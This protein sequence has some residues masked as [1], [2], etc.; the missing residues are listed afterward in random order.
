[1]SILSI[2]LPPELDAWLDLASGGKADEKAEMIRE[3]IRTFRD[4]R[5]G[6][7]GRSPEAKP[8]PEGGAAEGRCES[9]QETHRAKGPRLKPTP[10]SALELA[11]DVVGSVEGP[12]DLS[13]NPKYMEG[14]GR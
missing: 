8:F 6:S 10:G 1:M 3:A 12:G 9:P 5:I 2:E 4:A 7:N 13:Y 14:F 11:G